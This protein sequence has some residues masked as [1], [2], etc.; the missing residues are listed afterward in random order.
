[1][2]KSR[3]APLH[4]TITI[5]RLELSALAVGAKLVTYVSQQMDISFEHKFLGTDSTVALTWTKSDRQ[6]PVFVRNRVKTI[7]DH[8]TDVTINYVPTNSNPADIG[9]RGAT[10]IELQKMSLWWNGPP[11]L[12]KN[13]ERWMEQSTTPSR[14]HHTEDHDV[15]EGVLMAITRNN[16]QRD[17][18]VLHQLVNCTRFSKWKTLLNTMTKVLHFLVAKS[19]KAASIF[20]TN[21]IQLIR[22]AE[23]VLLR[24]A[25]QEVPPT[26]DQKVQLHLFQCEK[27]LLWKSEGR[28]NNA[29][30][31]QAAVT[32]TF[33]PNEHHITK[34]LI[35]YTHGENNHCGVNHTL[36][37]LRQKYWIPKGR[38]AVK[39]VIRNHCFHCRRYNAK[40]FALPRF[41]THPTQRVTKPQYPFQRM[42]MD[43]FGPMQYR[44]DHNTTQKYWMLL[45]TCL[46]S[47]AIYVD[48]V[49]NMTTQAVLHVLR[50]F[51]ATVGCPTWIICDNALSFKKVAECYSSFPETT[52]DD[53]IIDYCTQ[54]R[55]HVKFI[56]SLSPWQGGLYEKMI[57]IFKKSFRHA[58]GNSLLN[59]DDIR[60]IAKEAEAIVNTRPL[61]YITDDLDQN[62]LRPIDFLRPSALL[63][64]PQPAEN[65][66]DEWQPWSDTRD[67][68]LMVWR[69]TTGILDTFW[70]RWSKEYL[71]SL[72]EQFRTTHKTPRS[73][74]EEQPRLGDIVLIHDSTLHKGQWKA[75][76]ITGSGD[77]Y[78]RS[79]EIRL[80]SQRTITRP[81]N[82]VYK[83]EISSTNGSSLDIDKPTSNRN[84]ERNSNNNKTN[85]T[86]SIH[87]MTT[88]SKARQQ[89]NT[90]FTFIN[91]VLF[92]QLALAIDTRCPTDLTIN[93]TILYATNCAKEGVAVARYKNINTEGLC[94][95][96]V[97]CP[98]GAIR[99]A[100]PMKPNAT[101]CGSSCE[102]PT[103]AT[104]CSYTESDRTTFSSLSLLPPDIR[105][106]QPKQ[107][108]SFEASQKCD[109]KRQIGSFHQVQL[110][111]GNVLLVEELT[112]DIKEYISEMDFTCVDR[113]GWKRLPKRSITGTSRS[114]ERHRCTPNA[115]L[116]CAYGNPLA[117]LVINATDS[118]MTIPIKAWGTVTKSFF[119]FPEINLHV[120]TLKRECSLGGVTLNTD[121]TVEVAEVCIRNYCVFLR[122]WTSQSIIFPNALIMYDHLV[123]IKTW[124]NGELQHDS[125][126]TCKAHAICE[127]LQCH[128]CWEML[129]NYQCWSYKYGITI[130]LII[131]LL[132]AM[133]PAVY[134]LSRMIRLALHVI[135][136]IVRYC[137]SIGYMSPKRLH[138]AHRLPKYINRRKRNRRRAFVSCTI[139]ILLQLTCTIDGCSEVVTITTREEVCD[140]DG[141]QETCTFN[142]ATT[143]TL[144]LLQQQT[145]L[146]LNDPQN[147]PMGM[148]TI[149]PEGIKF[150]CNKKIEFYTRDHQIISESVHRCLRAG[151]CHADECH[152]IKG[153][154]KLEEFSDT[155]NKSPGYSSCSLSCSWLTCDGCFLPIP[156]CLFHR[157]Y[158][159]PTTS[160]VYSV[161]QCPSWELEVDAEVTLQQED[162]VTT[163][164]VVLHP[165][166]TS[167]WNNFHFSLIGTITPQLPILSSTFITNG[168]RTSII[169]SAQSGLL[170]SHSVGQLQ[171]S[172]RHAAE[173]FDCVFSRNICTCTTALHSATCTCSSGNVRDRM[174]SQPLPQASKNFIIFESNNNIYARTN[175]GSAIQLHIVAENLRITAL[176]HIS[177]CHV[178]TTTLSG[179]YSC[180]T[181]A[182]IIMSCTSDNHETLAQV[183]CG[184]HS[185]VLRCTESGFLNTVFFMFD[186]PTVAADCIAVCPGG[187]M[188]FTIEGSLVFINE[189]TIS[190]DTSATQVE[191][192]VQND[193]SF[194]N[195]IFSNFKNKLIAFVCGIASFFNFWSYFFLLII[196]L[197]LLN[198]LFRIGSRTSYDKVH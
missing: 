30:L 102:C 117:V 72:R 3:L 66:S 73:Y 1:M 54:K 59:I 10:T 50:R 47:R 87:P 80:A 79:V 57:D 43:F 98:Y 69:H 75:G 115:R 139:L 118:S 74:Q 130:L 49:L 94:W 121:N 92:C 70:Q 16:G 109:Q 106:Y 81:L 82:L 5:P 137:C 167:S 42:G 129:Y 25:Q 169:N 151:S 146:T 95:F 132:L 186:T 189:K 28:I 181:G 196:A 133:A 108:C 174:D 165:G 131:G 9:T 147:I 159:T 37:E 162:K 126:L 183:K 33:L 12:T 153:N 198:F 188:N 23:V 96:P 143:I 157:L 97:N 89:V 36:A 140:S 197:V 182:S 55:I 83:F 41:P 128:I 90:F 58:I 60:T 176:K 64:G 103:W 161:F 168:N 88:R 125:K 175:V 34:L 119:G 27:T 93:K 26:E 110:F 194:V 172:T 53:D 77:N 170:Q 113:K 32:P 76:R 68:L 100:F 135:R 184:Q 39:K 99:S 38:S 190:S 29:N 52:I 173:Q 6:V 185:H 136:L 171:C 7:Q 193:V 24:I 104:S 164:T 48:I 17:N 40:P 180:T 166:R 61:T 65:P 122:N 163:S 18:L 179:C 67:N 22:K 20:G 177:R 134:L 44:S 86:D 144:Q 84:E 123:S 14:A 19:K 51:I 156:S 35:L 149:K 141:N 71:T 56:P 105:S 2:A 63:C 8:T 78:K 160:T 138:Q 111:N 4:Q 187:T 31:P 152:K 178:E 158:A 13:P 101:L 21:H 192:Q 150:R 15:S 46:N 145:C 155:A 127:T 120:F 195:D 62:P 116:F 11:F 191:V 45:F 124:K 85:R 91:I 107:V 142:H 148:L 154:D 114:C 112:I